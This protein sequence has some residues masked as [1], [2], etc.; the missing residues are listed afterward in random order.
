ML[1]KPSSLSGPLTAGIVVAA[2][3]SPAPAAAA[4][5]DLDASFG[6]GG[7]VVTAEAVQVSVRDVVSVAGG[8][9][10][11][12][13]TAGLDSSPESWTVRLRDASGNV[14]SSYGTDGVAPVPDGYELSHP[15]AGALDDEG[16]LLVVG[17][18]GSRSGAVVRYLPD[19][20]LDHS[21][22]GVGARTFR[23]RDAASSLGSAVISDGRGGTFV[24]RGDTRSVRGKL[25]YP[26][27][28]LHFNKDGSRDR[29]F[30][31]RGSLRL[32]AWPE[33]ALDTRGRLL[34]AYPQFRDGPAAAA[35]RRYSRGGRADRTYGDN[36]RA[37]L[38]LGRRTLIAGLTTVGRRAVV[39][40]SVGRNAAPI[41]AALTPR[42]SLDRRFG[43]RGRVRIPDVRGKNT[44]VRDISSDAA[45][46]LVVAGWS[47]RNGSRSRPM[48]VRLTQ[49]GVFDN[50]FGRNGIST[51]QVRPSPVISAALSLNRDGD[52]FIGGD[53]GPFRN[54]SGFIA[55]LSG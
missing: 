52:I 22:A 20:Q 32:P 5:G 46:R 7:T 13:G 28:I 3:L 11:I 15:F 48:V 40:G 51:F 25:S 54:E 41:V 2:F 14:D 31:G 47:G 37:V 1:S 21:F 17:R 33:I 38:G 44:F 26:A 16:R 24:V 19:G 55:K 43:D 27:A 45:S 50:T 30:G 18:S 39:V 49:R 6:D 35:V 8:V 23:N 53:G 9:L 36:G 12:G 42:G 10:E 34:A 4:A 29:G